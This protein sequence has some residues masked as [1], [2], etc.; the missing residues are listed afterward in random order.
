MNKK[1][2]CIVGYGSHAKNKIIPQLIKNKKNILGVVT[3][4]KKLPFLNFKNLEEA[5]LCSNKNTIFIICSPPHIHSKQSKKILN[6]GFNVFIEKP[7]FTNIQ[8]LKKNIDISKKNKVF[9]L[10]NMMFE[11]SKTFRKFLKTFKKERK[12]ISD[13][14]LIFTI[15][16]Y[17]NKTFRSKKYNYS[18]NLFDIGC[19]PISL[20][21]KLFH[22]I[23]LKIF[24]IKN[25]QNLK[26]ELIFIKNTN[27]K[28][29][30]ILIKIG[31]DKFYEN[32]IILKCK[33]NKT[34]I[35]YP[36]FY[37]REGFRTI[38]IKNKTRN[39]LHILKEKNS[40]INLFNNSN[41]NLRKS[42]HSRNI[43]MLKN[44]S[45]LENLNNQY[46]K[47]INK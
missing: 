47:M 8:D 34:Y 21:N 4:K 39:K 3:S 28:K 9:F 36:F 42:Q 41:N 1:N 46:K 11:Y 12:I 32:K 20:L 19:Y 45:S 10:E 26:K 2:Y 7:I 17:P 18:T 31:I 27:F 13:M 35:F 6:S 15:P 29:I 30:K 33:K 5:I 23:D 44:L 43:L 16:D 40:F 37:G 25:I 22:Q 24:D 14:E 38:K